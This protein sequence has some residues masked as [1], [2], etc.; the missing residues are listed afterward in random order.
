[1]ALPASSQKG[2]QGMH[3]NKDVN[4]FQYSAHAIGIRLLVE[5]LFHLKSLD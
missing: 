4:M 1:M 5:D 3:N 2:E